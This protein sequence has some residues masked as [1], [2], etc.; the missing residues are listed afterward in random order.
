MMT[1]IASFCWEGRRPLPTALVLDALA[2]SSGH[3]LRELS[4]P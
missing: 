1:N 2:H 3:V 4:L